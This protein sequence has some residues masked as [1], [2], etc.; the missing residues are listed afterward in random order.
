MA[1]LFNELV[2]DEWVKGN[3]IVFSTTDFNE[4]L[5]RADVIV[6]QIFV[7][8]A[9]ASS[10]FTVAFEYSN[11]GK[12]WEQLSTKTLGS[13]TDTG[14]GSKDTKG[15]GSIGALG[16]MA[17]SAGASDSGRVQVWACGRSSD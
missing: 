11:D 6:Y 16:R 4:T 10:S 17:V 12:R 8:D 1:R 7:S 13:V 14:T 9:S 5:G 2:F 15:D 3:T